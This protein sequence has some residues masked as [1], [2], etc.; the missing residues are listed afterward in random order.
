MSGNLDR[1]F[2]KLAAEQLG[3]SE[4]DLHCLNIV[5]NGGGLTAGEV[6]VQSGL[7]T[8]AVTGVIDRLERAGY[9]RRVLDPADRRR[10]RVEVTPAFYDRAEHI[11]GPVA[12]DWHITLAQRFTAKELRRIIDFLLITNELSQHHLNRLKEMTP[13]PQPES[14][15]A[16]TPGMR[17][18]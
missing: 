12:T 15:A 3:V 13:L 17:E 1:A 4:S 16:A 9:L 5:E 6:A 10:V 8:G 11:W 2:D 7:T 14:G 18:S